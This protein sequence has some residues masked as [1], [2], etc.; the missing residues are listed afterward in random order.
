[1]HGRKCDKIVVD[2][3]IKSVDTMHGCKIMD[4]FFYI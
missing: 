3:D 2:M 1:M 4:K